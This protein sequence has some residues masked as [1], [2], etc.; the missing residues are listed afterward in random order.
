MSLGVT[1]KDSKG[2]DE[3]EPPQEQQGESRNDHGPN[4]STTEDPLDGPQKQTQNYQDH[5]GHTTGRDQVETSIS[6]GAKRRK[7]SITGFLN[8]SGPTEAIRKELIVL[9]NP[10]ENI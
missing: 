6:I 10:R 5:A 3:Q 7:Q 9:L 2:R 8:F 4:A 1:I